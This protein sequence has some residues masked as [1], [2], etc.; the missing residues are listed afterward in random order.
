MA[1]C[2]EQLVEFIRSRTQDMEQAVSHKLLALSLRTRRWNFRP[3]FVD[4]PNEIERLRCD[5]DDLQTRLKDAFKVVVDRVGDRLDRIEPQL[6]PVSLTSKVGTA[7]TSLALL[8]RKE[9]D[10]RTERTN[11][12]ASGLGSGWR[13]STRCR[14]CRCS[15]AA[16]RSRKNDRGEV[17]SDAGQVSVG[18][19]L[20]IRLARGK[21]E[22]DVRSI[23]E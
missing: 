21:I 6:T 17:V 22:A 8:S 23:E 2:E 19:K 7:R 20:D 15:N 3:C 13:R 5:A 11:R 9:P 12:S 16:T 18:D 4:F 10:G 1:A 14:R